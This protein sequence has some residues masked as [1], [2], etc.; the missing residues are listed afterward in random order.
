MRV[1]VCVCVGEYLRTGLSLDLLYNPLGHP[2]K[3]MIMLKYFHK[4]NLYF[5]FCYCPYIHSYTFMSLIN[6]VR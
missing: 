4:L 1:R 6:L 3:L 5:V 2:I